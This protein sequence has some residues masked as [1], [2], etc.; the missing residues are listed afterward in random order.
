[1]VKAMIFTGIA[2]ILISVGIIV[3]A[4]DAPE[5]NFFGEILKNLLCE[6]GEKVVVETY[7]TVGDDGNTTEFYCQ[8]EP[9]LR[10]NVTGQAVLIIMILFLIPFLLGLG[11]I[12]VSSMKSLQRDMPRLQAEML[13]L[14][15]SF[16]S[17]TPT[18][19]EQANKSLTERLQQLEEAY[20]QDLIS[21][22]EYT[23]T[24]QIILDSLNN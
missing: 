21:P 19:S 1:M 15:G 17:A 11:L 22:E 23:K 12:I 24:R 13:N 9:Q 6:S 14:G 18:T 20:E 16:P 2:L 10:R 7:Y 5:E 4:F 8:L 3:F